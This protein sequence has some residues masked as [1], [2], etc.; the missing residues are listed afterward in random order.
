M[1]SLDNFCCVLWVKHQRKIET[2][3]EF[4]LSGSQRSCEANV[5]LKSAGY[6]V[7]EN[8][9]NIKVTVVVI[10][11]EAQNVVVVFFSQCCFHIV[12]SFVCLRVDEQ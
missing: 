10:E 11:G 6:F 2:R 7:F 3:I 8:R 5:L 12:I 4:L 1:R 9:V